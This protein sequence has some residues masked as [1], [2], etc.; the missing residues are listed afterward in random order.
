M[1]KRKKLKVGRGTVG[2]TTV[3]RQKDSQTSQ[4]RARV[5]DSVDA[6]TLQRVVNNNVEVGTGG[7]YTDDPIT[8]AGVIGVQHKT[9]KHSVG[10]WVNGM[11]RTTGLVLFWSMF[12][13]AYHGMHYHLSKKHLNHNV[14][15]LAD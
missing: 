7:V 13:Q 15:R 3:A 10:R 2:R 14:Q 1:H 6:V 11:A 5:V 12:K 8:Y 9:C 4:L